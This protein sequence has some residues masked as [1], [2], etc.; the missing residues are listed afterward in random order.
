MPGGEG[1]RLQAVLHPLPVPDMGERQLRHTNHRVQR[2]ADIVA[3]GGKEI[4]FRPA[5]LLGQRQRCLQL[6]LL[7]AL[8][9]QHIRHIGP[10]Q[11]NRL[12][13]PVTP[14][15]ADLLIENFAVR[16]IGRHEIVTRRFLPQPQ[17]HGL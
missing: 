8:L 6:F 14:H 9:G 2:R 3:H 17:Q 15:D 10:H 12:A 1:D 7:P 16:L 5:G 11:A 13:V 4:A